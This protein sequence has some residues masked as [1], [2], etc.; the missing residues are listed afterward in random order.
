MRFPIR[1]P[2]RRA[3]VRLLLPAAAALALAPAARA[4]DC[5]MPGDEHQT[6]PMC[7]FAP[8]VTLTPGTA[9]VSQPSVAVAITA[10]DHVID[11]DTAASGSCSTAST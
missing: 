9:T 4:Q 10:T 5:Q 7:P 8:R 6:L 2:G 1:S 11:G 3:L